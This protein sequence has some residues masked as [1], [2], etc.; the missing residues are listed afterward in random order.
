[1]RL[2]LL[3]SAVFEF[4]T[5]KRVAEIAGEHDEPGALSDAL[6]DAAR[7][8]WF[9]FEVRTDDITCVVVQLR[10]GSNELDE[11]GVVRN[12]DSGHIKSAAKVMDV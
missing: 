10:E 11:S 1:M 4:L 2:T 3:A 9:E 12:G 6:A 5:N 8:S 7:K